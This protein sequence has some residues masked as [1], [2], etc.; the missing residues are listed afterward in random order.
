MTVED[1]TFGVRTLA[2][3]ESGAGPPLLLIHGLGGSARWWS[4]LVPSLSAAGFRTL[5]PDLPGF[6]RSA[7]PALSIDA[8]ARALTRFLERLDV[9]RLSVCGH[10]MG[11][12]IAAR[13]AADLQDRVRRLVLIDS[14]GIP[15]RSGRH[16]LEQ[17]TRP[18]RW[19]SVRFLP[20][21]LVDLGRA[22]PRSLWVGGRELRRYD[23]RPSLR[24]VAAP[25][26]LIW[27]GR[28]RLTPAEHADIMADAL[29]EARI[30][31]VPEARHLA[32][33]THPQQVA[34]RIVDFLS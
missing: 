33:L 5:A 21:L 17:L 22:G 32:I 31:W 18:W 26:L 8:S 34:E 30:E 1:A 16:A 28:D 14:A 20:A 29:G 12:A 2:Y 11:G 24:R 27:G 23:V 7:G 13:L 15:E 19:T 10:S 4:P 25:T 3:L 6:G 9:E